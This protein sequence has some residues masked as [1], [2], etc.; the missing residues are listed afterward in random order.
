[1]LTRSPKYTAE[2]NNWEK[3]YAFQRAQVKRGWYRFFGTCDPDGSKQEVKSMYDKI[4]GSDSDLDGLRRS[5]R[6]R[7]FAA[8]DADNF[9]EAL[10]EMLERIEK[11]TKAE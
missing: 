7:A 2:E 3:A 6:Q 4:Y 10:L 9:D 1:M 8:F 5:C 11:S